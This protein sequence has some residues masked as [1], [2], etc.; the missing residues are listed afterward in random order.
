[1]ERSFVV[2]KKVLSVQLM[3][4]GLDKAA[5]LAEG[6]R[7]E[8]PL[9]IILSL[10]RPDE[11][12]KRQKYIAS[13]LAKHGQQGSVD[14]YFMDRMEGAAGARRQDVLYWQNENHFADCILEW[15]YGKV[16]LDEKMRIG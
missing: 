10:L 16:C 8:V 4:G 1:M 13:Y 3:H 9:D 11:L 14:P 5:S 12:E 15:R 2:P 7:V 6:A